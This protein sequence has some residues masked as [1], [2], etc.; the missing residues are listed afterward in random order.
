MTKSVRVYTTAIRT[1]CC[2]SWKYLW[3]CE[4]SQPLITGV[5]TKERGTTHRHVCLHADIGEIQMQPEQWLHWKYTVQHFMGHSDS[6]KFYW[7]LQK[8]TCKQTKVKLCT[9]INHNLSTHTHAHIHT[10]SLVSSLVKYFTVKHDI[11]APNLQCVYTNLH[12]SVCAHDRNTQRSI[13]DT[14]KMKNHKWKLAWGSP[15]TQRR[16]FC[17]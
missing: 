6:K 7:G 3:S 11:W 8:C 10:C 14:R 17:A 13:E 15:F 9:M 5:H 1:I 12:A 4:S 16:H 2:V